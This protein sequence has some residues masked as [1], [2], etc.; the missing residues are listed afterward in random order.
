MQPGVQQGATARTLDNPDN[1]TSAFATNACMQMPDYSRPGSNTKMPN[2]QK[3]ALI[4]E[5]DRRLR[6]EI[7]APKQKKLQHPE[8]M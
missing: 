3:Q 7:G 6:N 5:T 1:G 8:H 4:A 2:R